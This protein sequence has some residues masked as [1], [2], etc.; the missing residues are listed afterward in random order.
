MNNDASLQKRE[1]FDSGDSIGLLDLAIVLAKNKKMIVV[2]TV[3]VMV[4][5]AGLTLLIPNKYTARAQVLPPQSQSGSSALLG[6]LGSLSGL[7]GGALKNPNDTYIGMLGSRTVSDNLIAQFKL[8]QVYDKKIHT[9]VRVELQNASSIMSSK[10]NVI[11]IDVTDE[12][13]KLAA[14]LANGYVSELQKLTS[15][16]AVTEASR[17]RLFFEKQLQQTK[18]E[19]VTAEMNLRKTQEATGLIKPNEQAEGV[20]K[21]AASIKAEIAAKEVALGGLRTFAT[22]NNPEFQRA[23]T[24]LAGLRAQLS[25]IERGAN[26]G[27][28]DISVAIRAIPEVGLEYVRN[29]RE[30]KYQETLLELFAKQFELAKIDEAKE[31]T[32][33]QV[34]DV[35]VVPDKKASPKR[36]LM[37]LLAGFVAFTLALFYAFAREVMVR[38]KNNPENASHWEQLMQSMKW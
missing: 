36:S 3:V 33:V 16:V 6:Q 31:G 37:V 35:A 18:G 27:Q 26:G 13:P 14:A 20:I 8:A 10:E 22:S 5:V 21:A 2:F 9:D 23:Q 24:E 11:M 32:L 4:M 29:L 12:D 25:K 1:N 30:V 7:A 15:T 17:R 19:L 38:I 34:L 28:G